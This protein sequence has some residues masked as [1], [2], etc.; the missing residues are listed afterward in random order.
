M[1]I[2]VLIRHGQSL[3]NIRKILTDDIEG[4]PLTE[5]GISQVEDTAAILS[6][7][8]FDRI[9]SSPVLRAYQTAEIISSAIRVPVE[10]V[11]DLRET[12]MGV[13]NGMNS[14]DALKALENGQRYESWD[15]HLRRLKRVMDSVD[16]KIIGVSHAMPIT[17]M[18]A[19]ILSLNQ[20]ESHGIDIPNASIT[21]LDL[22]NSK[23]LSIGSKRVS[24]RIATILNSS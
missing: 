22:E 5:E 3:S 6:E 13:F 11:N 18:V 7:F 12:E 10:K 14:K 24:H 23:V 8:R 2:L 16:G 19:S 9:W 1:K 20:E 17:V 21:V 4:F 15:S